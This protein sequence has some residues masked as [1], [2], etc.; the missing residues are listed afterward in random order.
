MGPD[1]LVPHTVF[2]HH[3]PRWRRAPFYATPTLLGS[4]A[5]AS[6]QTP[7]LALAWELVADASPDDPGFR[8]EALDELRR[9]YDW[10]GRER[11]PDG[12][13]LV[14]ILFPDESGLDDSPKYDPVFHRLAHW[15]PGYFRLVE[16]YRRLG[17]RA[18]DVIE[19]HDEHVED[20]LF[21]VAYALSLRAL[22]RL[23]GGEDYAQRA[24]RTERALLERCLDPATGLFFDLAGR[25]EQ[26]VRVSTWASLAPLALDGLPEDVRRR[27][28][29]E[30]L[31]DPRRYAAAVGIPSVAM[32]EPAF[33]PRFDRFRCWRGPSW[34]NS[35][36]LLVPA[37][38][39]LGYEDAA[40]GIVR[41]LAGAVE[42]HGFREYYNPHNGRGLGARDF[43]WSTLIVD[44][45][46][47]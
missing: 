39:R 26:P 36:W 13:G 3:S 20:V 15:R 47:A 18:A 23:G 14:S 42:S 16:R 46:A 21:N 41:S 45:A 7:L 31:L 4:F 29:E 19:H 44:L 38:Q 33:N 25:A 8:T 43:G 37:M 40:A 2:W 30:H 17:Y 32:D 10:L 24:D 5:T 12:D 28:V 35:A 27:L 34:V 11:D 22:A 6:T 1:G 9:H